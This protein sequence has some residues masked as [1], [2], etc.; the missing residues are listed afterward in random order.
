VQRLAAQP[1]AELP[2]VQETGRVVGLLDRSDVARW[3]ELRIGS[4]LHPAHR[5]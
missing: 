5:T 2:V 1:L 4:T 3:L